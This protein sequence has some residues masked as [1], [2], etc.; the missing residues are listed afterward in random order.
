MTPQTVIDLLQEAFKVGLELS[1]PMMLATLVVGVAVS[2]FQS[3]T[4]IQEQTLSFV[5]KILAVFV[6]VVVAFSWMLSVLMDFTTR[7]LAGIPGMIR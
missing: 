7:L 4:S 3:V 1:L 5:P 2:V 6:T